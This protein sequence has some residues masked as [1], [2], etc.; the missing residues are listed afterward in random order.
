M[1]SD[2]KRAEIARL[3]ESLGVFGLECLVIQGI[4]KMQRNL[5]TWLSWNGKR[6][7]VV[8]VSLLAC[9]LVSRV[10]TR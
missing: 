1:I 8:H 7:S 3:D 10:G 4:S 5:E 2:E 9:L 6:A